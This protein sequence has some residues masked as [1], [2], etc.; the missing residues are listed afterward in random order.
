VTPSTTEVLSIVSPMYTGAPNRMSTY[1]RLAR[2]F[3]EMSSTLWLNTT[4][5]TRPGGRIMSRKP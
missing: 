5:I 2:A 3:S 1:S 4:A